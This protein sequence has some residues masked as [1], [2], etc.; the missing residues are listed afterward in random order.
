MIGLLSLAARKEDNYLT[1]AE[2]FDL[3]ESGT[4]YVSSMSKDIFDFLLNC[5]SFDEKST[6]EERKAPDKFAPIREIWNIFISVCRDS[7]K[8]VSYVTVGKQLL[9]SRGG[10]PFR[11]YIPSKYDKYDVRTVVLCD[12]KT[13]Y[14]IDAIPYMG[15]GTNI[16][17][18]PLASFFVKQHNETI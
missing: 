18:E 8:P 6:R 5:L 9:E 11:I 10:C 14:I 2:L 1:S 13:N 15:K 12:S 3:A 7:F 16:N 17:G 4:K